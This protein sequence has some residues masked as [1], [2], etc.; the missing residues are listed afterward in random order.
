[1]RDD[2]VAVAALVEAALGGDERAWN[3]LVNRYAPLVMSVLARFRLS[4]ADAAD[5]S[6]ILWLRLVEH[7]GD[8]REPRALPRWVI[9][10]TR[11]EC[12]R[13][14]RAN[15]RAEPVD[16]LPE[17]GRGHID[18]TGL[19]EQILLAERSE[20]LLE[21]MAELPDRDRT[22][23]L[24]LVEDPPVPYAEIGKRLGVPVGS[25]G[26][27]RARALRKLRS[28]PALTALRDAGRDS[29]DVGGGQREIATVGG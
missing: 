18:H 4:G 23:L 5:V 13:L 26:P 19:D 9:T 17:L 28:S 2:R 14:L 7:L 15:R 27:T 20:A 22:L 12:I 1:M 21:A 24:L 25:I 29:A 11:N 10:T 16:T 3:Q 8:L 6:Q